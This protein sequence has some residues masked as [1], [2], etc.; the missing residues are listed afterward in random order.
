MKPRKRGAHPVALLKVED[1]LEDGSLLAKPQSRKGRKE[2]PS[3]RIVLPANDLWRRALPEKGARFLARM[4]RVEGEE[5]ETSYAVDIIRRLTPPKSSRLDERFWAIVQNDGG[6]FFLQPTKK[7]RARPLTLAL[8]ESKKF[9]LQTGDLVLARRQRGHGGRIEK[10]LGMAAKTG[11]W[12]RIAAQHH[13]LRE[14]FPKEVED[15]AKKLANGFEKKGRVDMTAL[16]FITIDPSDARDHDDAVHA[17]P[18]DDPRNPQGFR[19]DVAIADVAYYVL[20]QSALD[21]EAGRRGSSAYLAD[22]VLPMLPFKLSADL[23]SLKAGEERPALCASLT[24]DSAG[25]ILRYDFSRA[26]IKVRKN[27]AYED[28]QKARHQKTHE[29]LWGVHDALEKARSMRAPLEIALLEKKVVF[30][31]K[32]S[33]DIK[34]SPLLDSHRLVEN[35]MIAANIAAASY[36][37]AASVEALQ[38]AHEA[39]PQDKKA[40]LQSFLSSFGLSLAEE[41]KKGK[42][43]PGKNALKPRLFNK[44]LE[45]ARTPLEKEIFSLAIL[46]AQTQAHYSRKHK[47][48]FG[49]QC[50]LYAHFTSP[51]RRYADLVVHRALLEALD[52]KGRG[53]KRYDP[54]FLDETALHIS[55]RERIHQSAEYDTLDRYSAALFLGR[56]GE[57]FSGFIINVTRIGL[58]V[59]IAEYG[60]EGLLPLSSLSGRR[61]HFDP[62]K[63]T[64]S[65]GRGGEIFKIGMPIKVRLE[66]ASPITGGLKFSRA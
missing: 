34:E 14:D 18:D 44:I 9:N 25:T 5:E 50:D 24:L 40:E 42:T 53:A 47:G 57:S 54:A 46:R 49:L 61:F 43:K 60:A 63:Q 62:K 11:A 56:Q 8:S 29:S 26:F 21:E 33:F 12:G 65:S 27:W 59:R 39:P 48:H 30:T 10:S 6:A 51:I 52:S 7:G 66:E 58:F 1:T 17:C 37:S 23:C 32:D 41:V 2:K 19:L 22:R 16:D 15:E 20:P 4:R 45:K 55:E 3:V 13:G 38:R 35:C 36:L 31:N 64:L 28:F